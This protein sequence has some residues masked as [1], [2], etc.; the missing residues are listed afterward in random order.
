MTDV[1]YL[2]AVVLY[3]KACDSLSLLQCQTNASA[4]M[5]AMRETSFVG[6]SGIVRLDK[7]EDR[8]PGVR[9]HTCVH[10]SMSQGL[11]ANSC[12]SMPSSEVEGG[13]EGMCSAL[14]R[15]LAV[16]APSHTLS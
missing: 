5:E 4:M 15:C 8:I 16:T 13:E 9:M 7:N 6:K 3:A 11:Q 1:V 14:G 10:M 2:Q 12:N